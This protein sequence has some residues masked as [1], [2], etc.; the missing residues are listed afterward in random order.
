MP[1][2]TVPASLQWFELMR[3]LCLSVL[4]LLGACA[5]GG[6]Q[7]LSKSAPPEDVTAAGLA[8]EQALESWHRGEGENAEAALTR[9][10][11][12]LD[13]AVAA[14][15]ERRG[16]EAA[17]AL[18]AQSQALERMQLALIGRP[19]VDSPPAGATV[20]TTEPSTSQVVMPIEEIP[21]LARSVALLKGRKLDEV[22][23]L[24]EAVQAGIEEWL[25][26]MRPNLL[27]AHEHYQY[28]RHR[29]WPVYEQAGL[30]EALLFGIM[31]KES[32]GKVHAVSRAGAAGLLQFM[33]AT[34]ARFGLNRNGGFDERFDAR[35]ITEAN[36]AFLNDQFR[37]FNNDLEL[38]LAA[39]NGGEGRVGR[40][41]GGSKRRF[42]DAPVYNALPP[43][44]R[45]YVP[46]VLAAAWLFLHPDDYGVVFTRFDATPASI[47]LEHSASINELAVCMG[48][49]GNP[50]GWFR[51]LRN[52]NPRT[53][54]D[55]R[56]E[57]G[58]MLEVPK[59]AAD[60]YAARCRSGVLAQRS[61]ELHQARKP[62]GASGPMQASA[63]K[64]G[65][66]RTHLVRKGETLHSIARRFGCGVNSVA[67]ANGLRPPHYMIREGQ[68]LSL[69]SC[70]R[71]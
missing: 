68:R 25:T 36:V 57:A 49:F 23:V 26:W 4:I 1:A 31:A 45:E 43:E 41:A 51:T 13:T 14:C 50:R 16:C 12:R 10:R 6:S 59:A 32:G 3:I 15:V 61:V 65:P 53:E 66:G 62:A 9:A 8:L 70:G 24:N 7:Q 46:M 64:A 22:I 11:T 19:R 48:Q 20:E 28:L 60:A 67:A 52:L 2:V 17:A 29:M 63:G 5:G 30:P 18:Q 38:A 71:A 42:W 58:T 55:R 69:P 35:R 56:I 44:T 37:V 47:R 27:D 54:A 39:Y 21:E 34:A 40:L 33:P